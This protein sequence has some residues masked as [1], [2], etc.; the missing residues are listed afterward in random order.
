ML[1]ARQALTTF[2]A[3]SDVASASRPILLEYMKSSE[4]VEMSQDVYKR[5][6]L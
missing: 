5:Q 4:S 6:T 3:Y 1:S 2:A